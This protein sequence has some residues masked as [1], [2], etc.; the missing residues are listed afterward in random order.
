MKAEAAVLVGLG[1]FAGAE[2]N[3]ALLGDSIECLGHG[4]VL[5]GV[6]GNAM[7]RLSCFFAGVETIQNPDS[8]FLSLGEATI[9]AINRAKYHTEICSRMGLGCRGVR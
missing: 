7:R 3:M 6:R 2:G 4:G 9:N 8:T 1:A 5:G